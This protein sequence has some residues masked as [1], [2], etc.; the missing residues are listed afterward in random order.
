VNVATITHTIQAA[1]GP[2]TVQAQPATP[3]LYVYEIPANVDRDAPCRWRLGH[4]SGLLLAAYPTAEDAHQG[5]AAVADWTDWTQDTDVICA[6]V[7]GPDRDEYASRDLW[8][9]VAT[10]GG[11]FANC[12]HPA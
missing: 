10:S 1:L 3:G 7:I 5:A 2:E 6:R 11:H 8:D 12:A 4:H 9:R